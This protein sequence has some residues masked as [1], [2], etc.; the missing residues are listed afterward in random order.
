M[1]PHPSAPRT[2]SRPLPTFRSAQLVR[3]LALVAMAIFLPGAAHAAIASFSTNPPVLGSIIISNLTGSP[4]SPAHGSDTSPST[5]VNSLFTYV[6][7]DKTVPGQT[8]T[9][10]ADPNGYKVLAVT[11][12][13][14]VYNTFSWIPGINYTIRITRPLST[15]TLS[16]LATET[17][18]V[19]ADWT[20][21]NTCNFPSI[22][23]GASKGAG[24]GRYIT[25]T[26]DTPVP[27]AA[28]TT[29]GFDVGGG[30]VL[31][32]VSLYWETD[33]HYSNSTFDPY[34]G[35]TAYNSGY[36]NGTV[37]DGHGDNTMTNQQGDR[38]FVV[39][40]DPGSVVIPP[41]FT[42]QPRSGAFYTGV[43]AQF[44][45]K[46]AGD[47]NL[48]YQWQKDGG[49]LSDG[50]KFFGTLTD[51]LSISNV[52]AGD[53]GSYT[54]VVTNAAGAVTSA[55]PASLAV[56]TAPVPGSYAY[57]VYTNQALAYWRLNESVDPS[58]NPPTYDYI[59]GGV[60]TYETNALKANGPR[61]GVFPGF[62]S[63]N[64]ATQSRTTNGYMDHSWTTFSPL[65]LNTNTVT[66][67]AWIY[68][69]GAQ[70]EFAGLVFTY[71]GVTRAGMS[72][73]DHYTS[74]SGVGQL[75][76]SWNDDDIRA[77]PSG[78]TIPVNQWSFIALV[79]TP[80][81]GTLYLGST[82]GTLSAAT[83]STPHISEPWSGIW[84]AGYDPK[85]APPPQYV[86]NGIVDEVA[87]FERSL[88]LVEINALYNAAFTTPPA[89]VTLTIQ[90]VGSTVQVSW[91][92]GTLM[93]ASSLAGPWTTNNATSPYS[94]TPTA[95]TKFYRVIVR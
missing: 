52:G 51:T 64:T 22:G 38:V 19:T 43:T 90:K 11:L 89:S 7:F 34:P 8:F 67:A 93:E 88:S 32:N 84:T 24:T 71:A 86:F 77:F 78:L 80:T 42:R 50:A 54:L 81:N 27:L 2:L 75:V 36:W 92:Q 30:D 44:S 33:G 28:N 29:Y 20:D 53:V 55:P 5:N 31:T 9:T 66:L 79:I 37:G 95:A 94:V 10:G 35:G 4:P 68:P 69:N 6:A 65:Y 87:V 49:N 45:A 61:P 18:E 39:A 63:S 16:V 62:E 21:C 48:V 23:S 25:F 83:N 47:T 72:F 15:S 85:W 91:P 26:L 56:V 73:G 59:G 60:G 41:R 1:H 58:T 3:I 13:Q 46:A 82:N 12:R 57:T 76:Y 14:V 74:P 40:L 17:A 70:A